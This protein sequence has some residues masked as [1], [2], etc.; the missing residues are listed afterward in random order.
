MTPSERNDG[1]E[2]VAL[3]GPLRRIVAARVGDVHLVDEVVQETL[4]RVLHARDRVAD[5][6]L[7]PYAVVTARNL[8]ASHGR[9]DATA[10]RNAVRLVSLDEP[11]DPQETIVRAEEAAAIQT[12]LRALPD[13]DRETLIAHEVHDVDTLALAESRSST[14]GGVAARL[15]RA[16]ARMRV[17][18]VLALRR[19]DLPTA[20]CRPA[21]L[22][23]SAGDQR[24]QKALNAGSHLL[25]CST[26]AGLSEP[27]LGR[28]RVLAGVLPVGLLTR[29]SRIKPPRPS[30]RSMQQVGAAGAVIGVVTVVAVLALTGGEPDPQ[31]ASPGPTVVTPLPSQ[32]LVIG[33]GHPALTRPVLVDAAR[34]GQQVRAEDAT[35]LAVPVDEGLWLASGDGRIWVQLTGS[36]ES[37]FRARPGQRLYFVAQA[38]QHRQGFAHRIGLHDRDA[39]RRLDRQQVHLSVA[40][41]DIRAG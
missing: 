32:P 17:D 36:G 28:K 39:A 8:I 33:A 11:E 6:A 20:A 34:S 30:G 35:V 25:A 4:V 10:R 29:L 14:P 15:A 40:P 9:M 19:V 13:R 38:I 12:A 1:D 7:L 23:L 37:A 26:C 16:R 21:L 3:I 18:Y 31:A 2:V 5:D 24:R 41:E 27:L 22:A